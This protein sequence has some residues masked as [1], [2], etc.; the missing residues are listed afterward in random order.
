[1]RCR[2]DHRFMHINIP[3]ELLFVVCLKSNIVP[4]PLA[5]AI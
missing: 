3:Y 5:V 4:Q 1:M 2:T